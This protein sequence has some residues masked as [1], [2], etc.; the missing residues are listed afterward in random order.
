MRKLSVF[1]NPMVAAGSIAWL[2]LIPAN[3]G[4]AQTKPESYPVAAPLSQYFIPDRASEI[5]LAR[6]A[7][8]ASISG[9]AEVLVLDRDG[10]TTAVKGSNG[11]TCLVERGWAAATDDPVFWNPKVRGPICVNAPAERTY[12]PTVLLKARLVL[13]G[14]SRAE[15][16]QAV[17]S[18]LAG[19]KLPALEPDAM[20]YMM[21]KQQYLS[22]D[23]VHWHPHM[24]WF[25]PG[26]AEKMWGGNLPGSPTLAT[27]DPEDG[28]TILM[29]TVDHWSDGTPAPHA[30][31]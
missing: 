13:A 24:M 28:M 19:K 7:A 16:S 27:A 8:P 23:G 1:L 9:E 21:S 30:E 12:L 17:K 4:S 6:S 5:E 25:V 3:G 20:S 2:T 11:F 26:D 18:A 10:Y 14:K 15:I 22:D 31:H 29:I